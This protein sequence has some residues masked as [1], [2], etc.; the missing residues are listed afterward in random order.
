MKKILMLMLAAMMLLVS[1]SCAEPNVEMPEGGTNTPPA[2]TPEEPEKPEKPEKPEEPEEPVKITYEMIMPFATY[3]GPFCPPIAPPPDV[4]LPVYPY[5]DTLEAFQAAIMEHTFDDVTVDTTATT[6]YATQYYVP[7]IVPEGYELR[8]VRITPY[9]LEYTYAPIDRHDDFV[10]NI[11]DTIMI[12]VDTTPFENQDE[13]TKES[14]MQSLDESGFVEKQ[15]GGTNIVERLV[16][17]YIVHVEA[18]SRYDV[19]DYDHLRSLCALEKVTHVAG[20]GIVDNAV[21]EN[22]TAVK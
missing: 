10:H 16:D 18:W 2:T 9:S 6:Q 5:Y 14:F 15:V 7:A 12:Y 17:G 1:V 4:C 20:V 8:R 13:A 11:L 22:G 21:V 19:A 3:Q